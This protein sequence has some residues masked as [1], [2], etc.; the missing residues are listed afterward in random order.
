MLH[1]VCESEGCCMCCKA[2]YICYRGVQMA[3]NVVCA[4][5]V[6]LVLMQSSGPLTV[7]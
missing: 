6:C 3:L 7:L 4:L 5:S 1:V 2:A